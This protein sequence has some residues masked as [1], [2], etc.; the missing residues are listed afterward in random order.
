M[1]ATMPH[2]PTMT[3]VLR[4]IASLAADEIGSIRNRPLSPAESLAWTA[5]T[6]VGEEG[7][8]AL[9]LDSL[10]RIDVATRV[11]QFFHLHESGIED[12]LLT[13]PT[14]GGWERIVMEARR[15][16]VANVS[17]RTSGSTGE[18][19]TVTHAIADIA[20]EV[21]EQRTILPKATRILSLVPPHH[22]FGYIF[23]AALPEAAGLP[24]RDMRAVAPGR[25]R[26]E[27]TAGD[28]VVATPHLWH[29]L[30][31]SIS[32]FPAGVHG[33]TSTAPMPADL[34]RRLHQQGLASLTEIYGSSETA[35]IG[36]RRSPDA[37]FLLFDGWE[38]AQDGE[39]LR[40]AGGAWLPLPDRVAWEGE[41]ALRPVG[42]RDGA[43]QIGGI[44][45]FPARVAGV[46]R[47]H[48]AVAEAVVRAFAPGGDAARMRLKAFVV[49]QEPAADV[50]ALEENLRTFAA[51]RLTGVERPTAYAFGSALPRDPMGK[52]ADWD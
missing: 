9:G 12:Y 35:G 42:R 19:R 34:S 51:A 45:V 33:V 16:G 21:A 5:D 40:R 3:P 8:G 17:F 32:A 22:I 39:A 37:P 46:L 47:E 24:V 28:L 13:T 52:L 18:P 41:R 26:A 30:A 38:R 25:L 14:L 36:W 20:A 31:A 48:E 29:Y 11:N 50:Q 23:T 2:D 1:A 44:N 7:P 15:L 27:L 10:G 43:V 6:P 4:V 49:P